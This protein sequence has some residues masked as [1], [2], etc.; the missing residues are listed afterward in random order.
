MVKSTFV[1]LQVRQLSAETSHDFIEWCGLIEG[2]PS[3]THLDIGIKLM[4]QDLYYE[5]IQEYPDYAPK[6]KMTISRTRFYKWLT[7]YA[8][9]TTGIS[10][11]EGRDPS[12]RWL[13]LRNKHEAEVQTRLI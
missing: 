11:E 7:A 1:N 3:N 12:G 8:V 6:A 13:R 2:T 5:F 9:F 4:K 10:P